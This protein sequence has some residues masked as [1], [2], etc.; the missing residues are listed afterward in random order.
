VLSAGGGEY[1]PTNALAANDP[2]D[3]HLDAQIL[4]PP[5]LFK[6][7]RPEIQGAPDGISY[8]QQFK[9]V[10]PDAAVIQSASLVR[11]SS[12]THSFNPNQRINFLTPTAGPDFV[13]LT[14]PATANICPPG[15]YLLFL[16]NKAGVPSVAKIIKVHGPVAS[17][18][19]LSV[20]VVDQVTKNQAIIDSATRPE[21]LVGLTATCPYGLAAC[22]G[23]AYAGLKQLDGVG[24]VRPIADNAASVA[25]LYLDHDG[26]PD[27]EHWPAQFT[28]TTNGSYRWR[29]VE[30]TLQ[31]AVEADGG[32]LVL[33]A[34][35][36]RPAVVLA[37]LQSDA[38]VQLDMDNGVRRPL[39]IEE[40][41]A[42]ARLA[43]Q[44]QRTPGLLR[45]KVTG[46]LTKTAAGFV[47]QVRKLE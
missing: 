10:T 20:I 16:L 26:L 19:R 8:G 35:Q 24:V 32:V 23:G 25:F 47:L 31:G 38:K 15:H 37:P 28:R 6:G 21:V 2:V 36:H 11:L 34:D 22:W 30:V 45:A 43:D 27:I 33:P 13:T 46:P 29:G 4:S 39:P 17:P 9:V 5:Y 12:V 14:A 1:Q 42:Y 3:T 41:S 18:A 40:A 44:K 7:P